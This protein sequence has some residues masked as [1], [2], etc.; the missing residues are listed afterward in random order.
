MLFCYGCQEWKGIKF[1]VE[2][3]AEE[4]RTST[5]AVASGRVRSGCNCFPASLVSLQLMVHNF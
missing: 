2:A 3:A 1:Q 5:E 4:A